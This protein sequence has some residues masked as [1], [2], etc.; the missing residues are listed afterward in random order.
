MSTATHAPPDSTRDTTRDAV[1]RV[2]G[3]VRANVRLVMRNRL[4]LFYAVVMPLLPLL[5]TLAGSRGEVGPGAAAVIS[6]VMLA[7][8][9][10]VY[11]NTLSM[12]VTRRD[13]LVL[14]R[15]R[16]G[17]VRD[18]EL[19]G[20]L[21]LPG[22]I[23]ALLIAVA[24]LPLGLA[25]GVPAP[26]AP[27]LFVLTV[28]VASVT[29]ATLAFWTAAWTRNAEASQLTS[30]PVMVLLLAGQLAAGFPE[31]VR[32]WFSLTPGGAVTDLVRASWFGLAP[33]DAD[34][35]LGTLDAW[36]SAGVP[37]LV[38]VAWTVLGGWLAARSMRWEPRA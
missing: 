18:A 23:I 22:A 27:V 32:R 4:T 33:G 7:L 29:L 19:L 34:P 30:M 12:V 13:E 3:L 37:L 35:S 5:L 14:K 31:E 8:L 20:S 2:R 16:T 21:A 17:E 11:Y 1:R 25:L 38:L 24:T 9:F 15:L 28:A 26:E 6:V 36:A 10:P